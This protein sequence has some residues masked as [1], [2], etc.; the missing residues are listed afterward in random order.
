MQ[1]AEVAEIAEKN[2]LSVLSVLRGF[3]VRRGGDKR[4]SEV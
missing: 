1:T 4:K 3:R 2:Q